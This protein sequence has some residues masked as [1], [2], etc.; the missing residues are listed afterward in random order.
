MRWTET[1]SVCGNDRLWWR[2]RSGYLVC[3]VCCRDPLAPLAVLARRASTAAV[4]RV[5]TWRQA[6]EERTA[7]P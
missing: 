2:S 1:C 6:A 3:M 4:T 7:C 5:Q